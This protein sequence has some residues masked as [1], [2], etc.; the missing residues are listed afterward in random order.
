MKSENEASK[1][2]KKY[3]KPS[4]TEVVLNPAQ[5]ILSTCSLTATGGKAG[6]SSVKCKSTCQKAFSSGDSTGRC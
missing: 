3:E 4:I 1:K 6:T 5:A 2:K